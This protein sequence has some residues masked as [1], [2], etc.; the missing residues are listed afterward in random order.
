MNYLI[1]TIAIILMVISVT[2]IANC[3]IGIQCYNTCQSPDMNAEH[4]ANKQYIIIN[5]VIAIITLLISFGLVYVAWKIPGIPFDK[6]KDLMDG[7]QIFTKEDIENFKGKV[8]DNIK[9]LDLGLNEH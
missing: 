1:L 7:K 6:M 9:N 2:S 5:L 4:P 8:R 3:S